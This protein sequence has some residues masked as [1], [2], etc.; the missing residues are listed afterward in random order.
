MRTAMIGTIGLLA[1]IPVASLTEELSSWRTMTSTEAC[2]IRGGAC[3]QPNGAFVACP[4]A[5]SCETYQGLSNCAYCIGDKLVHCQA[6]GGQTLCYQTTTG[7]CSGKCVPTGENFWIN[8]CGWCTIKH[9][10]LATCRTNPLAACCFECYH[11]CC[12]F[13]KGTLKVVRLCNSTCPGP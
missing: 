1:F 13:C 9:T 10:C 6:V 11:T 2:A 12:G 4:A 7:W 5:Q 8:A 3:C